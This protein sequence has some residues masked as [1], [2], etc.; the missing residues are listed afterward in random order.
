MKK[1][2]YS[3]LTEQ[4]CRG[5]TRA[6]LGL[7]G[8]RSD[9]LREHLRNQLQGAPGSPN[10]FLADPVFEATFGWRNANITLQGLAGKLLNPKLVQAM[11]NP[12]REL[13]GDYAF[14]ARRR[15]YLHQYRSWQSLIEQRPPRSILVT[16]GTGSGKTE[17]FLVPILNDLADELTNRPARLVG[18]RALFLYPLNALIKSQKDRLIA[19]SEPFQGK[20]RFCL[21]N[22]DTP[23][24]CR[25]EWNSEVPDRK[26]LRALPPPILVTNTTMLEYM[27][28]RNVDQPI[29]EQSKGKLRWIVIDEAHTYIG[30]Q[31]AELTLLLRRVLHAFGCSVNNVHFVATS[32]TVAGDGKDAEEKLRNFLADIAGTTTDRVTIVTGERTIPPL[33]DLKGRDL[34]NLPGIEELRTLAPEAL[35]DFLANSAEARGIRAALAQKA[36]TLSD[37]S[38]SLYGNSDRESLERTL[39]LIDLCTQAKDA[40]GN[41]FLP[42]RGHIFQRGI[43]GLWACANASCPGRLGTPLDSSD[44]AFGKIFLERRTHCDACGCP[45]YELI[46]CGECGAEHLS[47]QEVSENTGEMLK[48]RTYPQ[49]EDEFQQEL[50]PLE[51]EEQEANASKVDESLIGLPRLIVPRNAGQLVGLLPDGGLD[52]SQQ[53]GFLI[54]LAT[55]DEKDHLLCHSCMKPEAGRRFFRPVRV[56]APF[57]L[58]TAIPILL[59]YLPV[60]SA[61][62]DPLPFDGRR[63]LGFTDSR[64]GTA[65]FAAKLQLETERNFVRSILYHAVAD[66]SQPPG[67]PDTQRAREE[68]LALEAAAIA[69]PILKDIVEKKRRDI[70]SMLSPPLGRLTWQEAIDRLLTDDSFKRWL[71]PP[72]QSQTFGLSD[73]QLAELCL[74]REFLFRPKRQFSMEGLGLLCLQYPTLERMD[75]VPAIAAQRN[76]NVQQWRALAQVAVDFQIRS[77]MSVAIPKDSLR[78]LGYPG[79]PSY[80]L[81]PGQNKTQ[82]NQQHWPSARN[83]VTR[84]SRLV[85]LL[86]CAENLSLEHSRDRATIEE[87]LLALWKTIRPLLS[88]TEIGFNLAI[89][90]QAEIVQV[91]QS[92]FCPTTRR[93]LP[94]TYKE[95]TPY[96]AP[97]SSEFHTK[98]KKV[99]MPIL[100]EPF[101]LEGGPDAAGRWLESD[102]NV[103]RLR[104]LGAWPDL[105]DRIA[106][107]ARYF[108]CAEHSAQIPGATLTRREN[109]FKSGKLNLLSCSTTMELGV[110]IGGLTAVAMNNVPPHPA[111]FLQRAGRAGRRGETTALSFVLCKSNPHG[112][113]V[114]RNPLWPFTTRLAVPRVSLQSAPIV[115]RHLNALALSAFLSKRK[116]ADVF[117]LTCG[118]FFEGDS[119]GQAAPWQTFQHW[120][121]TDALVENYLIQG[122][123]NLIHRT[124]ISGRPIHFLLHETAQQIEKVADGWRDECQS[125]LDNLDVV[126]TAEGNSKAEKAVRFQLERVRREYLLGELATRGYLPIYGFPSSVVCM[127]TTTA[128]EFERRRRQDDHF[129]EDNRSVRA[130][131]PSRALPI[132]IRDYAPGTDTVLDGRVYRSGGVTLNWQIPAEAEGPPEIQ[133]LRWVWRCDACGG[134]G[135]RLTMPKICP[136]CSEQDEKT[137]RCYEYIQPSGFA[138]DIRW[139]P[140]NDI[141]IPQYIPVR[142]PLISL[143]GADWLPLPVSALGRFRVSANGSMFHRTDGLHGEGFALCLRCGRADSMLPQGRLPKIFAE[144]NGQRVSHKRLRGGKDHDR[145]TECPGSHENW[146]IKRGIR[147]GATTRTEILEFQ[148][149]HLDGR[150]LDRVTAYSLNIALRRALAQRIGIEEGEI[151]AVVTPSR[152]EQ[153]LSVYS[154]HLYDTAPGGA[155]FVSQAVNWLPELFRAARDA[156]SCPRDCDAACQGC[157]LN[158]ETQYHIEQLDRKAVLSLLNQQYLDALELPVHLQVFGDST[159]LELEPLPLALRRELQRFDANEIRFYFNGAVSEWEPLAWKMHEPLVKLRANGCLIRLIIHRDSIKEMNV[160][161]RSELEAILILTGSE[162]FCVKSTKKFCGV[163]NNLFLSMEMGS[164]RKSIRWAGTEPAAMAPNPQWGSGIKDAQF[165]RVIMDKQLDG[166]EQDWRQL[167]ATDLR[168]PIKGFY[169]ISIGTELDGPVQS[170]G[171]R[172]WEIILRRVPEI[173]NLIEGLDQLQ[174]IEYSDRYLFS[175][176]ALMLLKEL[177]LSLRRYSGGI[178]A[179]TNLS[180]YTC[181]VSRNDTR[182]PRNIYHDWRDAGDR[183]DVFYSIFSPINMFELKENV[184]QVVPHGRVLH[185]KWKA[186]VEWALRLDQGLG[187]W[188]SVRTIET[189]PFNQKVDEQIAYINDA[190]IQICAGSNAYKT[191]W[192]IGP[193]LKEHDRT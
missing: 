21:Y 81:A 77:K 161:Q 79:S 19:W 58:Q 180:I 57:L 124:G 165:I 175:P 35:F 149:K 144:E 154:L 70:E 36:L 83:V 101:W 18:V 39:A 189:F 139:H 20:I 64:Q 89:G 54:S 178:G 66:R 12:P 127:V 117:K 174:A 114:F 32:A 104:S 143:E 115:Q 2:F 182:E 106:S 6:V 133:S 132:A 37:L 153:G 137:L 10:A 44:W 33:Q 121:E 65:R 191:H 82:R 171:R 94:V 85:Q 69:N 169:E 61:D 156:A 164:D 119:Q 99:E 13:V 5:A 29:I 172:A 118:W 68:L 185:L 28:V 177:I 93:L 47:A 51:E 103:A 162:L 188:R 138:V 184:K 84:K 151:G 186:G 168:K 157:L 98:C 155:G 8:F 192:Y 27:L 50:D 145:E 170:F 116:S 100:P 87:L 42:I 75:V 24:E 158:F 109:E 131:Y 125:L 15:P 146:A 120:C 129:R 17:C 140:H 108:R 62:L 48:H 193:S 3:S 152:D 52:W 126:S 7:V 163:K 9:A 96:L 141:T 16:S 167:R 34:R 23:E 76:I 86:A 107:F 26:G 122:I 45:A 110:D 92:W 53:N 160:A 72:L 40:Q 123:H 183:K 102:E 90:Q 142:E 56:G 179:E 41:P 111:N 11:R 95:I 91:R 4:L 187:Y 181:H 190:D 38:K 49:D 148:L 60:F 176:I 71:L 166:I 59:N 74:W 88:R 73:R 67:D 112:E 130:G 63:L 134:S 105:S 46:Q 135:T 113:A 128:E 30:S 1:S 173:K 78:W 25:Q 150:P 136:Y 159:R 31:A 14:P 147:I 80:A 43:R 97:V 22:G 55:T